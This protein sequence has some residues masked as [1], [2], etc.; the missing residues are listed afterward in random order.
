MLDIVLIKVM[1]LV[2][3]TL[4]CSRK[5]CA[6]IHMSIFQDGY[7]YYK[8]K[9]KRIIQKKALFELHSRVG[10]RPSCMGGI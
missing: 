7:N 9:K 5:K 2:L 3:D 1:F 10:E 8:N 6:G 4:Y